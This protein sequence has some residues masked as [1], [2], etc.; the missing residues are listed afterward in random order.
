MRAT[1]T[2]PRPQVASTRSTP[3]HAPDYLLLTSIIMLSVI[4]LIAV[5]SASYALGSAEFKDANYFIKKQ[6]L[7]FV[8][9]TVVM[10]VA[11]LIDYRVLM[12]LSLLIMFVAL[13]AL[14]LAAARCSTGRVR[15]ARSGIAPSAGSSIAPR[16]SRSGIGA[17]TPGSPISASSR[18]S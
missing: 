9:G 8:L 18:R 11:A 4:G 15:R 16:R 14:A 7:A 3:A 12:R 5:Y 2:Q 1:G 6:A 17:T 13:V 10:T